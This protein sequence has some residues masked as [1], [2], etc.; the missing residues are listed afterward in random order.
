M[1]NVAVFQRCLDA[2]SSRDVETLAS[3]STEDVEVRPLRAIVE[4]TIYRGRPGL[5]QWMRDIDETWLELRI[6]VEEIREP[7]P[8]FV[9]AVATIHGRGHGSE[10]PTQMPI[11]LT[12]R[13]RNGLVTRA[14]TYADRQ[15]ALREA[16][17]G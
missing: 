17:G 13:L 10:V 4:D 5:E 6:E 3:L 8:D 2:I 11:A 7:A 1:S 16:I 14:S 15:A 12:A 9:L